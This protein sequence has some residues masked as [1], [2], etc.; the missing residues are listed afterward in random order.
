MY[1]KYLVYL[2]FAPFFKSICI[3]NTSI[4]VFLGI[5]CMEVFDYN[6]FSQILIS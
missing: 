6:T 2:Y 5:L 3:R 1:S 4:K